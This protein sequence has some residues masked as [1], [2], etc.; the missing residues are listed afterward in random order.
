MK[1]FDTMTANQSK[2]LPQHVANEKHKFT[3]L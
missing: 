2:L 1:I 3:Q